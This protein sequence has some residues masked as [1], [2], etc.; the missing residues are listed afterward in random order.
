MA[1]AI[2]C[3]FPSWAGNTGATSGCDAALM[4]RK[5]AIAKYTR[6]SLRKKLGNRLG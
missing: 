2:P 4:R 1:Y 3:D 6:K 5:P